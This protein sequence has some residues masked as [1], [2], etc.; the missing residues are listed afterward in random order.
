LACAAALA[1]FDVFEDEKLLE[2]GRI[3][4]VALRARLE[5]L[6]SKY[7]EIGTVRGVGPMLALEFVANADPFQPNADFAQEV[8]DECREGGLLVIKCGLYRNTVRLLPP[9]NTPLDVAEAALDILRDAITRA[10][11]RQ[12]VA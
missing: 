11:A 3:L 9:L 7:K 2:K 4:G 1:V 5:K 8:I 10:R 6:A 12:G